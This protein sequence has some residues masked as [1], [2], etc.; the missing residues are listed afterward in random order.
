MPS[1]RAGMLEAGGKRIARFNV[2]GLPYA[3]DD[4]CIHRSGPLS[5]VELNG[6]EVACPWHGRRV[7][8]GRS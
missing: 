7:Q 1:N 5:E 3:I 2:D 8:R 6:K 4:T